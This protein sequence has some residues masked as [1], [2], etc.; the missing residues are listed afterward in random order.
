MP[1][2]KTD[3]VA[4]IIGKY[5]QAAG[6]TKRKSGRASFHMLRYSLASDLLEQ[7]I[8]ITT[9]SNILGHSTL[10]VTTAYYRTPKLQRRW[11]WNSDAK[12]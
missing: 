9:I 1:F 11:S 4:Y 3:N 2:A 6:I 12:G 5:A 7:N 10:N 8:P